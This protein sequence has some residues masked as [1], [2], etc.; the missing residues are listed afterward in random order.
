MN[1]L[2]KHKTIIKIKFTRNR[3]E[4][5]CQITIEFV[6]KFNE[7]T[8]LIIITYFCITYNEKNILVYFD[9]Q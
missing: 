2:L 3:N 9:K 7:L 1:E 6:Y 4:I 8:S 5:N